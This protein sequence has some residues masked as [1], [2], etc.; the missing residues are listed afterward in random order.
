MAALVVDANGVAV[1]GMKFGWE[2]LTAPAG[3]ISQDGRLTAGESIGDF[4]DAIRVTAVSQQ[5]DQRKLISTS[6]DVHVVDPVSAARLIS[7]TLVPQVISL[8]PK[9]QM[10]FTTM[11]LDRRGNRISP[12]APRWEILDPRAGTITQD[13]QFRAGVEPGIYSGA[14]RV[15]LELPGLEERVVPSGTVIIEDIALPSNLEP[16]QLLPRV[17]IYPSQVILSPGERA[18]VSIVGLDADIQKL[19]ST[20]VSWSLDPPRVGDVSQYITVTAHDFPGVYEGAIRAQVTLDTEDG[21][22]TR[23]VS[24]SLVIRGPLESVEITPQVDTLARG[25]KTQFRALAYDGNRI[26]LSDVHFRWSVTDPLAGIIDA[27]GVFT[28]EGLPGE[29]PG[30]VEVVAVQRPAS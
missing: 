28:A 14:V 12:M 9:E 13:G 17:A 26:L 19:S 18:R 27:N 6:L 11:V 20:N 10:R 1:S 7:A 15:S 16:E 25:E 22:V 3:S 5:G 2:I 21:P 29:Y 23:E 4:P 24:A 30:A 8:R